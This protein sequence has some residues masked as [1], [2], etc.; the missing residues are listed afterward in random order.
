MQSVRKNIVP[1]SNAK[2]HFLR[3]NAQREKILFPVLNYE[4]CCFFVKVY[5][6]KDVT[7]VAYIHLFLDFRMFFRQ[8][9][10]Y[11]AF[12]KKDKACISKY[13]ACNLKQVPCIFAYC[14]LLKINDLTKMQKICIYSVFIHVYILRIIYNVADMSY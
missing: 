11:K 14:R 7:S 10:P 9:K 13:M 4:Q 1:L 8:S 5:A 3:K 6:I 2:I 12:S